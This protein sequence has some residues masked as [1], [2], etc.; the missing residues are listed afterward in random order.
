MLKRFEPQAYAL[1]RIVAG[2]LFAM[3]G[4]QK[5]FGW[6]ASQQGG[7]SLPPLMI[8]AGVIELVAGLMILF[9]FFARIGGFLASGQMAVAFFM[10]HFPNGWNPVVNQGELA[11]IYAFAFL[12]IA[13]RGSAVW[14]LDAL[15]DGS[16]ER[17]SSDRAVVLTDDRLQPA[18]ARELRTAS[19]AR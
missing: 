5:L 18:P 6:P 9:G 2:F 17:V 15:R 1:F 16:P 8:A 13:A 11:V 3:H 12:F 7:G 10:A 19:R 14:S 4:S